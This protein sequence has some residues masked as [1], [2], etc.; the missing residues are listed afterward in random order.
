MA[1]V[2]QSDTMSVPP[3]P[4]DSPTLIGSVRAVWK[5][6][7]D[8]IEWLTAAWLPGLAARFVFLATLFGYYWNAALTKIDGSVFELSTGAYAQIIPPIIEAAGYDKSAVALPWT[9]LVY[10]GTYAEFVLPVLLVI[11]L[12]GRLA[13]LGMIG[14]VIVQSYVDLTFHGVD[15]ETAGAWFDR[16]PDSIIFDQRLLWLFP[17]IYLVLK[18]PGLLS[19]DGLLGRLF[20]KA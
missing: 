19:V 18:G 7:T 17:L 4:S 13:A 12:F 6:I 20:K 5:D 11:G 8:A 14:F 10:A 16:F 2:D 9:A 1:S 3:A 15:A